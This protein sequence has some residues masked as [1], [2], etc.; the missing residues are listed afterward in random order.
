MSVPQ[1]PQE[2]DAEF[3]AIIAGI[4]TGEQTEDES[5]YGVFARP[6]GVRVSLPES[7]LD[8]L[9]SMLDQLLMAVEA[10]SGPVYDRLVPSTYEGPTDQDEVDSSFVVAARLE[11]LALVRST[12]HQQDLD[13][14]E[15]IAWMKACA[16]ARAAIVASAGAVTYE[17]LE[18]LR[19]DPVTDSALSVLAAI[20]GLIAEAL[21]D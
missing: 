11:S 14:T 4:E 19:R 21:N 18:A 20:N 9:E 6:P 13:R 15:A 7:T 12:L 16:D 10:G 5:G 2:F 1:S 8:F 17:D 3:E